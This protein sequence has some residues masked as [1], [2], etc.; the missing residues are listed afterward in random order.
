ME[1]PLTHIGSLKNIKNWNKPVYGSNQ[2]WKQKIISINDINSKNIT[3][4]E[5]FELASVIKCLPKQWKEEV[6]TQND[7]LSFNCQRKRDI[8][9]K[10][11]SKTVY[12]NVIQKIIVAPSS[13]PFS[14][15]ILILKMK[16]LLKYTVFPSTQP[17]IL[18]W[19]LPNSK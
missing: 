19:E 11:K 6:Y 17:S 2:K 13:E 7:F 15:T 5:K 8:E 3:I 1:P 12:K 9:K 4:L 18:N 16:I 10:M 14:K